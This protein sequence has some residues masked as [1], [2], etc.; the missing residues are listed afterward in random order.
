MLKQAMK[1][2]NKTFNDSKKLKKQT[3][4]SLIEKMVLLKKQPIKK[5]LKP[6]FQSITD[7]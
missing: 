4:E 3:K 2:P 1:T 7:L 6:D 5:H